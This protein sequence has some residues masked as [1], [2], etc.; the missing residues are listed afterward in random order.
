MDGRSEYGPKR[1]RDRGVT[2]IVFLLAE[3]ER[4]VSGETITRPSPLTHATLCTLGT[5]YNLQP[6][7]FFSIPVLLRQ[8][9]CMSDPIQ[10]HTYDIGTLCS[11]MQSESSATLQAEIP[12]AGS[13]TRIQTICVF[14]Y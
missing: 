4:N 11:S 5:L 8:S 1:E 12:K 2:P 9:E 6:D 14:N 3:L 10:Y 13:N 7:A